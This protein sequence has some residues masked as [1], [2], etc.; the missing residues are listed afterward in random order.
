M[1]SDYERSN[2][3]WIVRMNEWWTMDSSYEQTMND[4]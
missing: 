1:N 4:E 3:Q 2:E